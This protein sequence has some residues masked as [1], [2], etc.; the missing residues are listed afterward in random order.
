VSAQKESNKHHSARHFLWQQ[1]ANLKIANRFSHNSR[2]FAPL[3]IVT[4]IIISS[5]PTNCPYIMSTELATQVSA[6]VGTSILLFYATSPSKSPPQRAARDDGNE[7]EDGLLSSVGLARVKKK[8]SFNR[9]VTSM[10]SSISSSS[11]WAAHAWESV[12]LDNSWSTVDFGSATELHAIY[13]RI[14]IVKRKSEEVPL[15]FRRKSWVGADFFMRHTLP[16]SE[17][18]DLGRYRL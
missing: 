17:S 3:F 9:R 4:Q 12:P 6:L 7:N 18:R 15:F 2:T 8:Y 10:A 11:W 14:H 13:N 16:T 5:H 1:Q